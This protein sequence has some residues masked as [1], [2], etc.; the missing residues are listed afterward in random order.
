[1]F[2][3]NLTEIPTLA[4]Q[5]DFSI[6]ALN[7]TPNIDSARDILLSKFKNACSFLYP[8][9]NNK[10][11][12]EAARNFTSLA[13]SRENTDH[14]FCVIDAAKLTAVAENALLK[15]LEEPKSS[16]H[17]IFLVT[18]PSTILPTILSRANLYYLKTKNITS[19]PVIA[20]EKTKA[21]AK[22]LIVAD[23][24]TLV[25]I[26]ND[27]SKKKENARDFSSEV[28]A[29]AIEILYKSY[30]ATNEKKFLKRLPNLLCLYDNLTKNGHIKLHLVADMI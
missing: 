30:F 16:H 6:F 21:L 8:E 26:A 1:M 5:A 4:S 11:S 7:S 24:K 15:N 9:K 2:F 14:F 28:V 13:D 22:Q 3:E 23:T 17:F 25:Q 19:A 29:T 27:L 12:V 10:I 18:S 20:D